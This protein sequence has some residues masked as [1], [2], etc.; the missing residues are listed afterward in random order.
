M[1]LSASAA[2]GGSLIAACGSDGLPSV[3]NPTVTGYL[4]TNWSQDP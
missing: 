4:R 3:S 1:A 2:A